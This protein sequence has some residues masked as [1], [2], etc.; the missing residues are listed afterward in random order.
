[1][2]YNIKQNPDGSTALVNELNSVEVLT[3]DAD[4]N[5]SFA[6][7][8]KVTTPTLATEAGTG[9]TTGTGT[10]VKTGVVNQGGIITTTMLLDITGLSSNVVTDII[11]KAAT[12]NS[13]IGQ[14]TTALNG[15]ILGGVM[16]CLEA[17]LTGEPDIDLWV[18]DEATGAEDTAITALTND[19]IIV[20]SGADWTL[21]LE[22]LVVAIPGDAQYLYLVGGGGTTD[23]VY[24]AGKFLIT[25]YGY[26][27]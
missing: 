5:V 23:A 11:G 1:M 16:K 14:L 4:N 13:N 3:L 25:F 21:G 7:A 18:A 2:G 22:K 27:A 8:N 6:S 9:I 26:V 20:T 12:A 10:I 17:P 19:Q 15:T 24:T